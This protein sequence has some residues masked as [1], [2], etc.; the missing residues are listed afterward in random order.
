MNT[1]GKITKTIKL[2]KNFQKIF[3]NKKFNF[4]KHITNYEDIS[5]QIYS[6]LWHNKI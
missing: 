5:F 3:N 1:R 2:M 4:K 6:K